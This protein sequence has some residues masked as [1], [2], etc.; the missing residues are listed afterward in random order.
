LKVRKFTCSREVRLQDGRQT[1]IR[2]LYVFW[3]VSD[4]ALATD[5][6]EMAWLSARDLVSSGQLRRWAYVSCFSMFPVGMEA[7]AW[8]RMKEFIATSVPEFQTATGP[9][10]LAQM[11]AR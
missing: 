4:A 8:E 9:A 6:W 11:E 3:F 7:P 5:P 2:A 10:A 1:K